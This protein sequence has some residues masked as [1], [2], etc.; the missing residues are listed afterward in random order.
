MK[1]ANCKKCAEPDV[2]AFRAGL[3]DFWKNLAEVGAQLAG[4]SF[5]LA[6]PPSRVA[7]GFCGFLQGA[8]TANKKCHTENTE[9]TERFACGEWWVFTQ[10]AQITQIYFSEK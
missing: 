2:H 5:R 10:I 1:I 7:F 8:P 9:I 3:L 4:T 6:H